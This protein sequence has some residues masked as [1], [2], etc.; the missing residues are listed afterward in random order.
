MMI[1]SWVR[2]LITNG[3]ILVG[4]FMLTVVAQAPDPPPASAPEPLS[5]TCY[6]PRSVWTTL[7]GFG[8]VFGG[9]PLDAWESADAHGI[10]NALFKLLFEVAVCGFYWPILSI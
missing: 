3:I 4:F 7:W 5:L 10:H 6:C 9:L 1:P 2:L 8:L